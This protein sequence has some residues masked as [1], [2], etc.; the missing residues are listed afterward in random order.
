MKNTVGKLDSEAVLINFF[1]I[2][3]L[4]FPVKLGHVSLEFTFLSNDFTGTS[5]LKILKSEK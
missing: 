2:I 1:I 4:D 5:V 3:S